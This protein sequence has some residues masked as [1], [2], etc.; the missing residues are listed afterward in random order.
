MIAISSGMG[1]I[2]DNGGGW[3]P[4]RTS[5]AALSMAW[6]CLALEAKSRGVACVL[7]QP[8]LG[9]DADGRR[10]APRSARKRAS[11]TCAR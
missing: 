6:S 11:A 10:R 4:D 7:L 8:R 1:S 9:E 2:G 3:V 5:K